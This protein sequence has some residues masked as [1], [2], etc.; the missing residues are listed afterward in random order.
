M[1]KKISK[2]AVYVRKSR[3]EEDEETLN[4][5]QTVLT[6]LCESN[7]WEYEVF[8]EVG[9]SQDLDR[10]ELQ[11]L[12]RNVKLFYY[13]GIVVADLDRLSR[14]V[15]HFGQIKQFLTNTG[16]V[17]ITPSKIYNFAK[18]EDDL[19]SDLQS[20]LAKNEYQT[21][22]KRL[23]RG[24][25]QSA[26]SGNW[27]GK[28][29]PVGYK[30]NRET[31]R[32]EVS[33]DAPVIRR[34]FDLYLEGV[35]TKA[36]A[37]RFTQEGVM[38]T[39][40]IKWT[41]AGVSRILNNIVYAGHSLYGKTTQKRVDGKRETKKTAP[42]EQILVEN[43]HESIV[44]QEEWERVQ[45]LKKERNSRPIALK[46]GKHAFSGLIRCGICGAV[47]SFQSSRGGKKRINSCQT[48]NY[49][50]DLTSY[51][52]C[53]NKGSNM[54]PFEELFYN[55]FSAYVDQLEEYV[56]LIK[57]NEPSDN[58]KS[59]EV[60]NKKKQIA[61]LEQAVQR[62]QD[63]F[64]FG[65]FDAEEAQRDIKK[66][67]RQIALLEEQIASIEDEEEDD[68]GYVEQT[69]ER[70]KSFMTGRYTM[71]EREKNEILREF[72]DHI[73]YI[74]TGKEINLEIHLRE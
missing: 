33:E 8:R 58:K 26:K 37:I 47:H 3:P 15:I 65:I 43:T 66:L 17:A 60:D 19:F 30:Y 9:S 6:D 55:Q 14:N 52:L 1:E 61:K 69:L 57:G 5:Q 67:K 42:E 74:K 62:V 71:D 63:G 59:S 72:V 16:T 73:V 70:M 29:A 2:V 35:G 41:P 28:K 64:T 54:E 48:R 20:V 53:P 38:T 56:N 4:R 32:L 25:I 44:S 34:L 31:K 27:L 12:L 13:D 36:I 68:M 40:G 11:K 50:D 45:Q 21:I 24:T 39:V 23:V 51:S 18:Q 22:R 7:G 49:N 46:L 10:P